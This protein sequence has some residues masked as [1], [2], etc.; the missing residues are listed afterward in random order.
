MFGNMFEKLEEQRAVIRE[1]LDAHRITHGD[2]EGNVTVTVS[3]FRQ[4]V[5]LS[6][7]ADFVDREQLEDL[8]IVLMNEALDKA[9][10]YEAE[11][12]QNSIQNMM[13]PG[14]DALTNLFNR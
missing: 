7:K 12:T 14:F 5:D 6:I 13:P 4:L 11:L 8:I 2:P 10:A 3:G 9:A 1:K